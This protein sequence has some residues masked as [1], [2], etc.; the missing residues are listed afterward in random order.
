MFF[1]HV[2]ELLST[3][4]NFP[5]PR[6]KPRSGGAGKP[7]DSV[8]ETIGRFEV[9][10]EKLNK[11]R[12]TII[13][14]IFI[15]VI[16]LCLGIFLS[17]NTPLVSGWLIRQYAKQVLPPDTAVAVDISSQ[18]FYFPGTLLFKD[19]QVTISERN[20]RNEPRQ[21][22]IDQ[23]AV[24]GIDHI[25]RRQ[26]VIRFDLQGLRL[27]SSEVV[28]EDVDVRGDLSIDKNSLKDIFGHL[29]LKKGRFYFYTIEHL[30][31]VFNGDSSELNLGHIVADSYGG[32][33][34][35]DVNLSLNP[36]ASFVTRF[37]FED[38]DSQRMQGINE[39]IFSQIEGKVKGSLY[40]KGEGNNF[41][42]FKADVQLAQ[43]GKIQAALFSFLMQYIPKSR[44]RGELER[45]IKIGGKVPVET[46]SCQIKNFTDTS[47]SGL[48][49]MTSRKLNLNINVPIDINIDKRINSLSGILEQFSLK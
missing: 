24:F 44:E 48:C 14:L 19:V 47:V 22:K 2:I 46:G 36:T 23:L 29:T 5:G 8:K 42:E 49:Q 33:V 9:G 13:G 32:K 21:I 18:K 39:V 12:R 15:I 3:N 16:V 6:V 45:L 11:R 40:V 4:R 20:Q 28:L 37:V 7:P 30:K 17:L 25:F 27:E 10:K 41:D 1:K 35:G 26:K 31:S 34:R 38:L 43:G